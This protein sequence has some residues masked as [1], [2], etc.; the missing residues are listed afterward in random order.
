MNITFVTGIDGAS[1]HRDTQEQLITD[2]EPTE[3][4]LTK[5]F[6]R[7]IK[8]HIQIG[9]AQHVFSSFRVFIYSVRRAIGAI[10]PVRDPEKPLLDRRLLSTTDRGLGL[11]VPARGG[12]V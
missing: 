8:R 5:R 7:D 12:S 10:L 9:N 11:S 1:S 3:N 4:C 2:V 6:F